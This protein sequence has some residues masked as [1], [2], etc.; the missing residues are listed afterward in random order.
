MVKLND[1][2]I[3]TLKEAIQLLEKADCHIQM[4]LPIEHNDMCRSINT[5]V[6][7]IITYIQ[8]VISC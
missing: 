8:A 5:Q 1:N 3:N 6:N 7:D 4:T 2:E